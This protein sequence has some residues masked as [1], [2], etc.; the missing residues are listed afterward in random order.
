MNASIQCNVLRYIAAV[1]P[2]GVCNVIRYIV[3]ALLAA[4]LSSSTAV[5]KDKAPPGFYANYTGFAIAAAPVLPARE[6]HPS[7][8][9]KTADIPALKNKLAANDFARARWAA[10]LKLADLTAALP[11]APAATDKVE[12]IHKYYGAVSI[13]AR[14][15]ALVSLFTDDAAG[16]TAH[17]ARAIELLLRAYDGPIFQLD[18]KVQGSAVDEIYRGSWLQN[19]A[20]AY[21]CIQSTLDRDLDDK[22]RVRLVLEAECVYENLYAWTPDSPHNHLSK[23]AWG[24]GSMALALPTHPHAKAWLARAIEAGNKNTRY[25]FSGDGI[26]REGSHYLMFSLTN[27]LPFLYHYRNVSGVDAFPAFQPAF[28]NMIEARNSHGWLPNIED[29]YIRPTPTHLAAAA[30]RTARTRLHS[31]AP[32]AEILAWSYATCDLAPFEKERTD[33]GLNYTG[34]SWDY[35]LEL[36]ELLTH[37]ASIHATAPDAA[38]TIFLAGGQSYFRDSWTKRAAGQRYLLFHGVA[39][40]DNH[41]HDDQLSF[42]LEA[43]GQMM[44]SD[45]GYSRGTYTGEERTKWYNTAPAHNTLTFDGQPAVDAAP[46]AT[47]PSLFHTAGLGLVGEEKEAFFG[48]DATT[49]WRRALFWIAGDYYIVVDRVQAPQPGKIAAY[50]HGGRGTLATDGARRTWNYSA[51]RYGPAAQLHSW[52][53]A[54]GATVTEKKGELTYIKGDF[55][56]FPYL[57]V[58]ATAGT[59]AWL[60]LLQPAHAGDTTA[61]TAEDRSTAAFAALAISAADHHCLVAAQSKSG[62]RLKLDDVE[63]DAAFVLVRRDLTGRVLAFSVLDGTSLSVSGREIWRATQPQSAARTLSP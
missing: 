11:D 26:Y 46:S 30:Y 44:C 31:S 33:S 17:R 61:F 51:D 34:A 47:P 29:S 1:P 41:N 38:P 21:D 40:A 43:E 15:H 5:A 62:T 58:N 8:W 53:A 49:T 12:T 60:T 59:C 9:F 7:L 39:I 18:S 23:P 42:L 27:F 55:A 25:F 28:E 20:H 50:L 16:R 24:L 2:R 4:W 19:Y 63:T 45:A 13:A 48:K 52:I 54:P 57:E 32:L 22:I 10:I 35:P 14:A 37:D 6:T 3:G 36:D 56:E